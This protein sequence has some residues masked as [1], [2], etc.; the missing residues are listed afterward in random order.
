MNFNMTPRTLYIYYLNVAQ[1]IYHLLMLER[2]KGEVGQERI[3][4]KSY[5]LLLFDKTMEVTMG[6]EGA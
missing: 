2:K 6:N 5:I 4:E 1:L 3:I